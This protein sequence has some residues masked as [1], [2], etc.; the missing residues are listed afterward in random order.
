MLRSLT[1]KGFKSLRDV[2]AC[3]P[4]FTV[5]FGPNAA[6]KSNFLD[7]IQVLSRIATSRTLSDALS[8]PIRGYPIEA[9]SFPQDGLAGLLSQKEAEF[10]L[11]AD[12]EAGKEHFK[13]RYSLKVRIHPSRRSDKSERILVRIDEARRTERA[14]CRRGGGSAEDS[15]EEQAGQSS[16]GANRVQLCDPFGSKGLAVSNTGQ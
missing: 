13:Y 9:F 12:I 4:R 7:A 16:S 15:K 6:G 1:V 14:L 8:D 3:L 2:T 11:S 5:L 10:S